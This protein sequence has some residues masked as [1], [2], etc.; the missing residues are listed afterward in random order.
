MVT[1]LVGH[2]SLSTIS[3]TM[4]QAFEALAIADVANFLFMNLRYYDGLETAYI[5]LDL[6]LSELQEAASRRDQAIETLEQNYTTTANN[7]IP[8]LWS[9]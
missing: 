2:V 9:I 8:Y 4:Q 3:P 1:L 5:N 7:A 6:K